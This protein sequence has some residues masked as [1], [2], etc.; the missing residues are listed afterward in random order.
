[1]RSWL[2]TALLAGVA[3]A[4]GHVVGRALAPGERPATESPPA[5]VTPDRVPPSPVGGASTSTSPRHAN[6]QPANPEPLEE[7]EAT[8][9]AA[10]AATR[11]ALVRAGEKLYLELLER[12]GPA[13]ACAEPGFL[14]DTIIKVRYR[15]VSTA[16]SL[17]LGPGTVAHDDLPEPV[18][19]CLARYLDH[20]VT[21]SAEEAGHPLVPLDVDVIEYLATDDIRTSA[22]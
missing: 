19:A 5:G 7:S 18:R 13:S 3:I 2:V 15:V 11:N 16:E 9:P 8:D 1:M 10:A 4:S 14:E 6:V 20:R 17:A 22:E 21:M 12:K